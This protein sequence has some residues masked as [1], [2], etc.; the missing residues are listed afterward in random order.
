MYQLTQLSVHLLQP[1][2][3][4]D[5]QLDSNKIQCYACKKMDDILKNCPTR[6]AS[7]NRETHGGV[8]PRRVSFADDNERDRMNFIEIQDESRKKKIDHFE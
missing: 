3:F 7:S 5:A 6:D 1:R 4:C 2:S 8:L